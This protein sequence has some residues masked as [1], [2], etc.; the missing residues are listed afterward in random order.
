MGKTVDASTWIKLVAPKC[1]I[2]VMEKQCQF[3]LKMPRWNNKK[4]LNLLNL[5]LWYRFTQY[6]MWQNGKYI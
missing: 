1:A 4:S 6:S 5:D 3:H 2:I